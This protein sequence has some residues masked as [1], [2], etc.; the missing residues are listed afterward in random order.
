MCL[1]LLHYAL[2]F[3]RE[4]RFLLWMTDGDFSVVPLQELIIMGKLFS[5]FFIEVLFQPFGQTLP[6]GEKAISI[7]I[8]S[9][10]LQRYYE[11]KWV[12]SASLTSPVRRCTYSTCLPP[13]SSPPSTVAW[14]LLFLSAPVPTLPLVL[15]VPHAVLP[16]L[17]SD[18]RWWTQSLKGSPWGCYSL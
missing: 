17:W 8:K 13:P 1:H 14:A 6:P 11:S 7:D 18:T 2:L 16:T 10:K 15:S 9:P 4:C 3:W 12:K 5:H